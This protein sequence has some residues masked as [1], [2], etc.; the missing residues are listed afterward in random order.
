MQSLDDHRGERMAGAEH[1]DLEARMRRSI[2][3]Y[4]EAAMVFAAVALGLPDRLRSNSATAGEL[5]ADLGL[6]APHLHRFLRG[7]TSLGICEERPDRNFTL[8][9]AGHC[10]ASGTDSNLREKALVVVD[11][12]WL[13]WLE[14]VHCLQTGKP[15][16]PNIYDMPI[17]DWRHANPEQGALFQRYLAK[18]DLAQANSIMEAFD[19]FD[20]RTLASIGGGYGGLLIPFLWGFPDL[21]GMLFDTAETVRAAQPLLE[22]FG[23]ADRVRCV[24]GDILAEIPV[25]AEVYLLKGVLQQWADAEARTILENCRRPMPP[26]AKLMIIERLMPERAVDDPA[27]IMLDLHMMTITGG[28]ARTVAEFEALLSQAG[29]KRSKTTSTHALTI[30]EAVPV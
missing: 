19:V 13:P 11:Q 23:V 14:L 26:S 8:T 24:G 4:H 16:F 20:A 7:L 5:A 10:L 2:D 3:A 28:R 22:F 21:Q 1:D 12:Y 18:E 15:S 30:I 27:A 29:L 25:E 6:S 17:S 9:P